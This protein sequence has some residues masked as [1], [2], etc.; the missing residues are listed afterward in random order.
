[1]ARGF[2]TRRWPHSP[3]VF[4]RDRGHARRRFRRR[5]WRRPPAVFGPA[6]ATRARGCRAQAWPARP[7]LPDSTMRPTRAVSDPI[8]ATPSAVSEHGMA[9]G[10]PARPRLLP[11]GGSAAIMQGSPRC[12]ISRPWYGEWCVSRSRAPT[13]RRRRCG[14]SWRT[15]VGSG[16]RQRRRPIGYPTGRRHRRCGSASNRAAGPA[17]GDRAGSCST[18]WRARS[19]PSW[20]HPT[21]PTSRWSCTSAPVGTRSGTTWQLPTVRPGRSPVWSSTPSTGIRGIPRRSSGRAR[22]PNRDRP[23]RRQWPPCASW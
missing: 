7:T 17:G 14:S 13:R 10:R 9:R 15:T 11:C 5:P 12:P 19:A 2:R 22:R 8:A 16:R 20:L 1:M 4:G 3:A 18:R 23:T 21:T 6:M